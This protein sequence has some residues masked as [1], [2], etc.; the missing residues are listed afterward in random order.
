MN[1]RIDEARF[2]ELHPDKQLAKCRPLR[3]G[4]EFACREWCRLVDTKAHPA[5][6]G[7]VCM[8]TDFDVANQKYTVSLLGRGRGWHFSAIRPYRL[9]LLTSESTLQELSDGDDKLEKD[10]DE[11]EFGMQATRNDQEV[12]ASGSESKK[13]KNAGS[14]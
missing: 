8:I 6:E 3:E 7:S 13:E 11:I 1:Q 4:Q 9:R 10:L 2:E 14:Q 12:A 5:F